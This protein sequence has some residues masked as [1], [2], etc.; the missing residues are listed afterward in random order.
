MRTLDLDLEE[1]GLP[2]DSQLLHV[3][4]SN[5]YIILK[6]RDNEVL[7]PP[8]PSTD[9]RLGDELERPRM[10]LGVNVLT[11]YLNIQMFEHISPCVLQK[12]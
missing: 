9:H 12:V 1:L 11:G 3:I 6:Q 8:I 7:P 2:L 4:I 10:P 5:S